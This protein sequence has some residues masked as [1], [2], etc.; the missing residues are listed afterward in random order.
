MSFRGQALA[1]SLALAASGLIASAEAVAARDPKPSG[2]GG[3]AA[4][5]SLSTAGVGQPLTLSGSGFAP[6]SQYVL[7]M[8][9]PAGSGGTTVNT[10]SNGSLSYNTFASWAGVYSAQLMTESHHSTVA[11]SCS[12]TVA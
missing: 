12:T 2:G 6:N 8:T 3:T 10:D 1:I 11:A 4:S 5:C 9:S 7:F